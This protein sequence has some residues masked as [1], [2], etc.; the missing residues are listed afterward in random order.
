MLYDENPPVDLVWERAERFWVCRTVFASGD[1][2]APS[3]L[4]EPEPVR[5]FPIP[6]KPGHGIFRAHLG[7]QDVLLVVGDVEVAGFCDAAKPRLLEAD[8]VDAM[9]D[10]E[11]LGCLVIGVVLN[12]PRTTSQYYVHHL[13]CPNI[14]I[15]RMETTK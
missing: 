14:N 11:L 4:L 8:V 15:K 10:P 3:P 7:T 5:G 12:V 1:L 13:F 6:Y 2:S 9:H